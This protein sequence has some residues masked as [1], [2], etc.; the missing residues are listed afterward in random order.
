V[1]G[2]EAVASSC[3]R[4]DLDWILGKISLLKEWSDIGTG[5]PGNQKDWAGSLDLRKT[6]DSSLTLN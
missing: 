1:I 2:R 3:V 4:G 6:R 5:C